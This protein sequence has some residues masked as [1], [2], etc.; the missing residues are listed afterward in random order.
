MEKGAYVFVKKQGGQLKKKAILLIAIILSGCSEP[1]NNTTKGAI[2]GTAIGSGLGA[3]IGGATGHAG[4]GTAV[5]AGVGAVTGTL[6]GALFDSSEEADKRANDRVTATDRSIAANQQ[7][8][9]ELRRRGADVSVTDRG[10]A[11]HLPDI[12]FDFNRS[13]L[14]PEARSTVREIASVISE[15]APGHR[16]LVEGHTD[17]VGSESYN[18]ELSERRADSVALA[19]ISGG[20]RRSDVLSKGFGEIRPIASNNDETGRHRNRRVEVIVER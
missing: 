17:S 13:E 14:N 11:I 20:V 8:I 19:L 15:K 9:D 18:K 6:I 16:V 2:T 5:G 10:V 3:I 1:I 4:P 7:L 12:L